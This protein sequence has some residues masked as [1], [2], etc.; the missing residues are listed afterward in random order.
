MDKLDA[1]SVNVTAIR[2]EVSDMRN[3]LTA[4]QTDVTDSSARLTDMRITLYL[5]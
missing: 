5:K 3:T 1:L 4:L 2:T